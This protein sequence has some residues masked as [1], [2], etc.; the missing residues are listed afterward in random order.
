MRSAI[1]KKI[2]KLWFL[3][4]LV[5]LSISC[6]K[7]NSDK[8]V[9]TQSTPEVMDPNGILYFLISQEKRNKFRQYTDTIR[10]SSDSD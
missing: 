9:Q 3:I 6:A 4:L 2:L 7:E 8:I 1:V 10:T 5:G